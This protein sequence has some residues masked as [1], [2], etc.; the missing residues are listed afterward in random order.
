M[1]AVSVIVL[2]L[3]GVAL[4]VAILGVAI[5]LGRGGDGLSAPGRRAGDSPAGS[6]ASHRKPADDQH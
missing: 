5:A 3:L 2:F 1:T 6:T 4:T